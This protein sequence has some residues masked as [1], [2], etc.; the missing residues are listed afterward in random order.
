MRELRPT[1]SIIAVGRAPIHRAPFRPE[2]RITCCIRAACSWNAGGPEGGVLR[3]KKRP[4]LLGRTLDIPVAAPL[5]PGCRLSCV[6]TTGTLA[7]ITW[8]SRICAAPT[9]N[10]RLVLTPLPKSAL[11]TEVTPARTRAFV[12]TML[13][14]ENTG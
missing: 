6:G 7:V 5:R 3:V 13:A 1:G 14:L 10:V 9:P 4:E 12:N 2:S 11:A 8:A